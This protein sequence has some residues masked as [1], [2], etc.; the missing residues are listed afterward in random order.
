MVQGL[1][2]L[3]TISLLPFLC[4]HLNRPSILNTMPRLWWKTQVKSH[5]SS[6]ANP[7]RAPITPRKKL[8]ALTWLTRCPPLWFPPPG[9]LYPGCL[10]CSHSPVPVP[11]THLA[12][13]TSA[14]HKI[15]CGLFPTI[16]VPALEIRV[17]F[18]NQTSSPQFPS[19]SPLLF[20]SLSLETPTITRLNAVC[21]WVAFLSLPTECKWCETRD[22]AL[23]P[24]TSLVP[25]TQ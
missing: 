1:L 3:H 14:Q 24:P 22:S 25:D 6:A 11:Q 17:P 5:H 8:K 21:F 4:I 7:T 9:H 20:C 23:L 16:L 10:H 18:P 19:L 2:P 12:A 15:T 13:L